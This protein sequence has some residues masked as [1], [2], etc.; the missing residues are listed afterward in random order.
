MSDIIKTFESSLLV[1][2]FIISFII[3]QTTTSDDDK[4]NVLNDNSTSGK[5]LK[6]CPLLGTLYFY[7]TY[8]IYKSSFGLP[9][10]G[11][12]DNNDTNKKYFIFISSMFFSLISFFN[13]YKNTIMSLFIQTL[14]CISFFAF[15]YFHYKTVGYK[16]ITLFIYPIIINLM[17]FIIS[18][19]I[20]NN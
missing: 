8:L 12:S 17:Y 3:L 5:I 1:V 14:A 15:T 11:M 7:F 20:L 16:N 18:L 19:D 13:I 6:L 2:I 4:I 9:N 10:Y